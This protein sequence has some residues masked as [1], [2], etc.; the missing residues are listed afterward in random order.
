MQSLATTKMETIYVYGGNTVIRNIY[1]RVKTPCET[2]ARLKLWYKNT[3]LCLFA[4][5]I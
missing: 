4:R 3:G 1:R 5:A 2:D